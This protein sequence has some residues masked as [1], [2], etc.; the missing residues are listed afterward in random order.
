[1]CPENT[2]RDNISRR[3]SAKW[4]L[5]DALRRN[6]VHTLSVRVTPIPEALLDIVS[7]VEKEGR[8]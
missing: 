8:K 4:A 7:S 6:E 5:L 1:M 3:L 2:G